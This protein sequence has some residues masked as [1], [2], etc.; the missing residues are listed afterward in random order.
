MNIGTMFSTTNRNLENFLHM[1]KV[2]FVSQ[3]KTE[4]QLTQWTYVVT[5]RFL[6]VFNEYRSLRDVK[7][8]PA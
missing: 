7:S 5:P 8:D 4:D 1:H 3:Q 6:E 2:R